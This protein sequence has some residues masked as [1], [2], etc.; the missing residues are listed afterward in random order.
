LL[1]FQT[2]AKEG[3]VSTKELTSLLTSLGEKM[4]EQDVM[5]MYSQH[6][7]DSKANLTQEEFERIFLVK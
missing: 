2:F 1:H 3:G 7:L 6:G 5:E 4:T